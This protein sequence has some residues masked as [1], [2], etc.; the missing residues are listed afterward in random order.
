VQAY[1]ETRST[2]VSDRHERLRARLVNLLALAVLT[3]ASLMVLLPILWTISTSLRLPRESFTLPPKWLP[4]DFRWEN[5]A[6]VFEAAPFGLYILNS[7]KVTFSIVIGQLVTA[8][9]AAY[10]FARLRFPGRDVL[11]IV[12]MSAMMVPL[13]VTIIPIF[14]LVRNLNLA[15]THASLILPALITPFGV[16]LLRQFFMTIPVELE[17]A[18]KIDGASPWQI[19]LKVILPLGAPGL[20]VLAILSFN[21]HWN[22]FFRPLIFLNSWENFTVPLGLVTLRGYMGTGS[23]SVVV[24]GVTIA[25]V[26]IVI[27]FVLAQ[28]YLIEGIALTGIKG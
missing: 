22:E 5:Y 19:F 2:V 23:V 11:F 1:A 12:L 18:A 27:L 26:P 4:T 17:E 21:A 20:S 7:F 16:F 15:D 13:F 8:S 3:I 14:L 25:L 28:R 10:A 6:E 9:M 24:A